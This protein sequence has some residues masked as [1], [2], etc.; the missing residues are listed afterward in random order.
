MGVH[1]KVNEVVSNSTWLW[2][3]SWVTKYPQLLQIHMPIFSTQADDVLWLGIDGLVHNFS[4]QQVWEVIR[5]RSSSVVWFRVVWFSQCIP[6]HAFLV[7]LLMGERLKTQ[8]KF[9]S[10]EIHNGMRLLCLLCN[11][12]P[13]SHDHLFFD[14]KF[15]SLVWSKEAAMT[16]LPQR[17]N[18]RHLC[19][20]MSGSA[21]RNTSNMVVAKLIF[22][23][24]VY[25]I[26]QEHNN[27]I[28]KKSHRTE[29][30]LFDD[31]FSTIRLKLLSIK[32]KNLANVER[33]KATWQIH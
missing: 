26:W 5:P 19:V 13:D 31:I 21:A 15:S 28:F 4:V 27:R 25:F 1:S 20:V 10:W 33:M 17:T 7:W 12:C 30:K 24:S 14:C 22:G 32:F 8:D 2:P 29:V 11:E 23:A 16:W 6:R 9:K 18:W 3:H